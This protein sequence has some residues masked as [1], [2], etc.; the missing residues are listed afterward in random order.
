VLE[1]SGGASSGH[2]PSR[3]E[4]RKRH[5]SHR[6]PRQGADFDS[7]SVLASE[8]C[9]Q[10]TARF[11]SSG[12]DP[13]NHYIHVAGAIQGK[14][15]DPRSDL[16]AFGII[17]HEML[18]SEHPWPRKSTVDTLHAI[19]HDDP[20]PIRTAAL[21][22]LASVVQKLL[23]KNPADRYPSAEAVLDALTSR[24]SSRTELENHQPAPL[25]VLPG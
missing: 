15:T 24:A 13:R 5:G 6:W 2:H 16:F 1:A 21:V 9:L 8:W 22:G 7:R 4:A 23:R 18:T 19:L 14:E 10:V 3:S 17:L 11:E 25:H 12:S 20:P